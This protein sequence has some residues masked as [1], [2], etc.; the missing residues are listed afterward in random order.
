MSD[1]E[2]RPEGIVCIINNFCYG[3]DGEERHGSEKDVAALVKVFS[4]FN[5]KFV[6]D[7]KPYHSDPDQDEIETLMKKVVEKS[8]NDEIPRFVFVMAHGTKTKLKDGKGNLY[9]PNETILKYFNCQNAPQLEN[10]L[11]F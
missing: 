8:N 1:L 5:W 11:N 4:K 2:K 9:D 6:E 3:Q 7:N 10:T